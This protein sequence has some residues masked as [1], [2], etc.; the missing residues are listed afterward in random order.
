MPSREL[1]EI[2]KFNEHDVEVVRV[3][4][5]RGI[6]I[7]LFPDRPISVRTNQ[8]VSLKQ[9][10]DFLQAKS[11]WIEKHQKRFDLLA[12][13]FPKPQVKQ[14]ERFPYLGELKYLQ[15]YPDRIKNYK[16]SI[17]DGFLICRCP[18]ASPINDEAF[19]AELKKF[20]KKQAITELSER[21][22]KWQSETGLKAVRLNFRSNRSRWGS[23]SSQKHI[24]LNWKLICQSPALIDY[25]IVHELCHLRHMNHS[26]D[27][28][29]L[30]EAFLPSYREVE[31]VLHD[32][33][34][35]GNFLS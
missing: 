27:F 20:Y 33:E 34:Q 35:L 24:S 32:Q 22:L 6:V 7:R 30:V 5:R 9:V 3:K 14:G 8:S 19:F 25:V 18:A 29:G 11:S 12:Q 31:Q 4:G 17:E 1:K 23:C 10:T 2:V 28:W 26:A 21:F 13:R 16:F 15:F